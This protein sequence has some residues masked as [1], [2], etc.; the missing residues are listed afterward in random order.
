MVSGGQTPS[1]CPDTGLSPEVRFQTLENKAL[2]RGIRGNEHPYLLKSLYGKVTNFPLPSC[3]HIFAI[4][5]LYFVSSLLMRS[6]P[7]FHCNDVAAFRHRHKS[8]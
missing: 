1:Q 5:T 7:P 2:S 3:S 8:G 6:S 4:S